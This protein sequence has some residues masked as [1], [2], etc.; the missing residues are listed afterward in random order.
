LRFHSKVPGLAVVDN[1]DGA[2]MLLKEKPYL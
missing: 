2:W 1:A